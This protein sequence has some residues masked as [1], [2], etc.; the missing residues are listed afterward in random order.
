[1]NPRTRIRLVGLSLLVCLL[2]PASPAVVPAGAATPPSAQAPE[3][4]PGAGQLVAVN[5]TEL[6]VRRKNEGGGEPIVIVHGGPVLEH[7][8]LLPWLAPLADTYEV[9]FYDQRLSGRSAAEVPAESVRVATFVDDIEA[10]RR[11]LGLGRVHLVAHSWGGH[12]ALQYALRHGESLRS[13]VLLDPMAASTELWQQEEAAL[14]GRLTAAERAEMQAMRSSDAVQAGDPDAIAALLK[15][16]FRAQFHDPSRAD[17]L[18]LY[19]PADYQARSRRFGA[20]AVDLSFDLHPR[21]AEIPVPTLV[22]YGAAEPGL[23]LGG[24]ALHRGIPDSRLVVIER[25]GHFPFLE[26]PDATL[27]AIREF[28]ASVVSA[29]RTD[30]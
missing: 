5:G 7:G 22:L 17:D 26:R 4:G 27:A 1:M 13:L 25:A 28:L 29:A 21:L 10:L 19:V 11:Q 15:A 12:L 3:T 24:R 6:F 20:M 9:V 2:A 18:E 23:E 8:Y 30:G 14:A 16:S